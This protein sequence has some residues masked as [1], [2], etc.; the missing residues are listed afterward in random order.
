MRADK[1]KDHIEDRNMVMQVLLVIVTL[2]I[3][4][5]YWYYV[6][7]KELHIANRKDQSAGPYTL[8]FLIPFISLIAWWHYAS[9]LS[10]FTDEKYPAILTFLLWIFISLAVWLL[11]QLELNKAAREVRLASPGLASAEG[12]PAEETN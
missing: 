8:L 12:E 3:Y 1:T 5:V 11:A 2:G 9:E 6:T 7:L 4:V 10:D